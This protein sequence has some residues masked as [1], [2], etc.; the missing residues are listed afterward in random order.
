MLRV[1]VIGGASRA[2]QLHAMLVHP[3]DAHP[4]LNEALVIGR[5]AVRRPAE[6]KRKQI[7]VEAIQLLAG[8][9]FGQSPAAAWWYTS[10]HFSSRM[11]PR[12]V[13][14]ASITN[15]SVSVIAAKS[16]M[17]SVPTAVVRTV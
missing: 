12:M 17:A 15:S 6:H 3:V 8:L 1:S 16:S 5:A 2:D 10:F 7:T 13:V 9:A 14:S 4:E 11:N